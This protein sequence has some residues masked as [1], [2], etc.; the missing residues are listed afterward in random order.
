[1]KGS[2]EVSHKVREECWHV[3][4]KRVQRAQRMEEGE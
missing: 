3:L 2:P 1:M 4:D